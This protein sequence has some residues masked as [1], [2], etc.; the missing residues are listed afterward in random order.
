MSDWFETL[1]GIHTRVWDRL[2]RGVHDRNAP[3]RHPVLATVTPDGLPAARTVVLRGADRAKA[4]LQVHTDLAAPK[5]ADLRARP[6]AALHVWD[7]GQRLQIRIT[8]QA[9]IL[10]GA[11]VAEIWARIPDPA[12]EVYGATPTTGNPIPQAL[13]YAK[14]ADPAAFAVVALGVTRIDALHLGAQH[15][16]AAFT[17]DTSWAGTWLVP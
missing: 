9:R 1:D 15:R 8:A 10:S 4:T 3:A 2:L 5:I 14:P 11:E 16:R 6:V 12:R 17:C 7:A 13:A